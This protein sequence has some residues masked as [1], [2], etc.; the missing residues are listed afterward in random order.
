MSETILQA[1]SLDLDPFSLAYFDDPFPAQAAMRDA[2]PV[3]HLQRYDCFA[4]ARHAPVQA[5]L[6]AH[7]A[8]CSGRGVGL[9]DFAKEAPWRAKSIILEADPPDHT[10]A[11]AIL[12]RVLSP[13]AMRKMR[14]A[15]DQPAEAL[16][17]RLLEADGGRCDGVADIAEAFPMQVFPDAVGLGQAGREHL[18]PY[19]SLA[20]DA[21]GPDNALRRTALAGAAPHVAW[22]TAQ[23][24]REALTPD[25]LGAAVYAAAAEAGDVSEAEAG[26]L[27]RSLLTAGLDTTV[28]GL[29]AALLCL[30][31]DP[32]AWAALREAPER[33]ARPS[34]EEAL[35]LESPV[36]T[37]FRTATRDVEVEGV[38]VPE[39]AKMLMFLGAANRDPRKWDEPDAYLPARRTAGHV[40]FGSGVH[41]CVGAALA[42]LE[43]EALLGALAR[44]VALIEG[45]GPP[46]RKYNNTLRALAHLPLRL[47]AA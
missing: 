40:G 29:G 27:L 21:F 33:L 38:T 24:R 28:S 31:H 11:R 47:H 14:T 12:A 15:F 7:E 36:Q 19:A 4:V 10:R 22:V 34:Y 8:F 37:F 30:S 41:V 39:G 20:F 35:R 25:G 23:C 32:A 9:S 46:V 16:V 45:L 2:G 1:T 17:T 43:G 18:L 6:H 44:R 3:C 26:M 42:R 5:V 13:A